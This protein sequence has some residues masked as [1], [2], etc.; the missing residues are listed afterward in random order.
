[1]KNLNY[2]IIGNCLSAALVSDTGSIDW[3]CLPNFSSSSIFAKLLDRQ[4]G[5]N[6][7]IIVN[8]DL[9]N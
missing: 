3:C 9:D 2:G 8:N 6:F 4:K 5:G 1:M 7:E